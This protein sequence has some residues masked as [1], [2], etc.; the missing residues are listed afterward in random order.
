MAALPVPPP[1][2]RLEHADDALICR[3]DGHCPSSRLDVV[4]G[5]ELIF[6]SMVEPMDAV[7]GF[8]LTHE[9]V[10]YRHALRLVF[11][12]VEALHCGLQGSP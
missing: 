2:A 10:S 12:T 5:F 4:G 8:E 11:R 7:S 1:S 6:H 3:G 9:G